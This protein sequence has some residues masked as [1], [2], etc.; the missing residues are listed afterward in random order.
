M[1]LN[2]GPWDS[3]ATDFDES[4]VSTGS[5]THRLMVTKAGECLD[6]MITHLRGVR[7]TRNVILKE[8]LWVYRSEKQYIER[9]ID[10]DSLAWI[11]I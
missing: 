10:L 1:M 9:E 11:E 8:S 3:F 2:G 5:R 7:R 6:Q 4:N